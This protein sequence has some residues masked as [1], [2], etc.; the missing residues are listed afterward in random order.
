MNTALSLQIS[1]QKL[2]IAKTQHMYVLAGGTDSFVCSRSWAG[3]D[4]RAT[5]ATNNQTARHCLAACFSSAGCVGAPA[6][7]SPELNTTGLAQPASRRS[8]QFISAPCVSALR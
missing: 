1:S 7:M 3:M 8:T 5:P 4:M 2:L 6:P